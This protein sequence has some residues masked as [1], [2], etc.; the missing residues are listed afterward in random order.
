MRIVG[1]DGNVGIGTTSPDQ[2]LSV[3]GKIHAEEI[4]VDLSVP[5]D[6]VFQKYYTGK[7]EL[8]VLPRKTITCR[9]FSGKKAII[10][11]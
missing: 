1:Q 5:A 11:V 9:H 6:Y 8:K 7:S 4:I 2:K 10:K 3:K